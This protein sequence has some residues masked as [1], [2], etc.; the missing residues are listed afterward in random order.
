MASISKT[1][2]EKWGVDPGWE[3]EVPFN[4]KTMLQ[5]YIHLEYF[6][7]YRM[8]WRS[9]TCALDGKAKQ[10]DKTP[11]PHPFLLVHTFPTYSKSVPSLS[12]HSLHFTSVSRVTSLVVCCG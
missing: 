11:F 9:Q 10:K 5:K 1:V 6:H 12:P 2:K 3:S 4:M 7:I 8:L